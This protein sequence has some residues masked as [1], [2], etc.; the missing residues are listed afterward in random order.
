MT[1]STQKQ[2]CLYC[3]S[4]ALSAIHE[5]KYV[6]DHC[7][8]DHIPEQAPPDPE[9]TVP[10]EDIYYSCSNCGLIYSQLETDRETERLNRIEF[11]QG[12]DNPDDAIGEIEVLESARQLM[13]KGEWENALDVLFKQGFPFTH[14]LEFAICRNICQ[15]AKYFDCPKNLLYRRYKHLDNLLAAVKAMDFF[16]KNCGTKPDARTVHIYEVLILLGSTPHTDYTV[17]PIEGNPKVM[18]PGFTDQTCRKLTDVLGTYAQRLERQYGIS[19][20]VKYLKM[21]AELWHQCLEKAKDDW[22]AFA[23]LKEDDYLRLPTALRED[24]ITKAELLD[25]QILLREPDYI[26]LK[27][28]RR[29][30]I[31]PHGCFYFIILGATIAVIGVI[32]LV[33]LYMPINSFTWSV[34]KLLLGKRGETIIFVLIPFLCIVLPIFIMIIAEHFKNKPTNKK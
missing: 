23:T 19:G 15:T 20:D 13:T 7:G 9:D 29:S 28:P 10:P 32:A 17:S 25:K 30:L 24:I 6:I 5:D 18:R 14:P 8:K 4:P 16:E 26:P 33:G 3:G 12:L 21:S 22:L 2:T 1:E 34:S 31:L 27:T 11:Y